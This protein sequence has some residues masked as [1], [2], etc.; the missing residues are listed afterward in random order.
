MLSSRSFLPAINCC[1]F[2]TLGG[3]DAV[4][5]DSGMDIHVDDIVIMWSSGNFRADI[6]LHAT[7]TGTCRCI[8]SPG[9]YS[10]EGVICI[11]ADNG[12][13][14]TCGYVTAWIRS[15]STFQNVAKRRPGKHL[16][17]ILVCRLAYGDIGRFKLHWR[18]ILREWCLDERYVYRLQSINPM[19]TS[20]LGQTCWRHGTQ[21]HLFTGH[22]HCALTDSSPDQ[23]EWKDAHWQQWK[24]IWINGRNGSGMEWTNGMEPWNQ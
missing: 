4:Y 23:V 6:T 16:L 3:D 7:D 2:K 20:H 19:V 15:P 18:Q 10:G 9:Q 21:L 22:K 8:I 17:T 1:G 13:E 24:P 14:F 5:Y 12:R 11:K